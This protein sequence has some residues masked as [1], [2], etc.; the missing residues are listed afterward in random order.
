MAAEQST[1]FEGRRRFLK[2][3]GALCVYF[4]A[5]LD[6]LGATEDVAAKSVDPALVGGYLKISSDGRLTVYSGKVDLGTGVRTAL[7]QIVADELDFAFSRVELLQ[8]DTALTPDQGVTFGSLSIQNGGVQLRQAAA[9][10]RQ[11]L[12][13]EAG[14]RFKVPPESLRV[15]DG[16]VYAPQAAPVAL[17]ALIDKQGLSLKLDKTAPL[18]AP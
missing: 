10:A 3:S 14:R 8:G 18:K 7:S 12:L 16:M 6:R 17:A 4:A 1:L 9:T 13:I 15:E 5:G 2:V 11:A